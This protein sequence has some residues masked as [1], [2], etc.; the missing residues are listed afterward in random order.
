MILNGGLR[1]K[2]IAANLNSCFLGFLPE[3]LSALWFPLGPRPVRAVLLPPGDAVV[4]QANELEGHAW[5]D[6]GVSLRSKL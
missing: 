1:P 6:A 4:A 2:F 5:C 3:D